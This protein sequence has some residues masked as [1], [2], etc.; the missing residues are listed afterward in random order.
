MLGLK[1]HFPALPLAFLVRVHRGCVCSAT[2]DLLA[3]LCSGEADRARFCAE[4][5]T[6]FLHI[7]GTNFIQKGFGL[8]FIKNSE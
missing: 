1:A 8:E 4:A 5:E 7:S 6:R 3:W 2:S